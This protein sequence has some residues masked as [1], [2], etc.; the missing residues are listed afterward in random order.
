[1]MARFDE[2]YWWIE[3]TRRKPSLMWEDKEVNWAVRRWNIE[4][5]GEAYKRVEKHTHTALQPCA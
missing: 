5:L 1:M 3:E 4:K 2:D